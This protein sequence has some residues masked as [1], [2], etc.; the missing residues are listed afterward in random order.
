MISPARRKASYGM[1][2]MSK[3]KQTVFA[4]QIDHFDY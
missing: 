1:K 4:T 3:K 2:K